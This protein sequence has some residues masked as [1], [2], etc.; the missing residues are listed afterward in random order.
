MLATGRSVREARLLNP[1]HLQTLVT[2]VR[3]GSFADAAR[4]LGYTPSAVS[5][6]IAALERAVRVP[7]FE[8]QAHSITPS[9]TAHL[10]ATRAQHALSELG[11]LEADV[12]AMTT[13]DIGFV[14]VGSF[15]TASKRIVPRWLAAHHTTTPGIDVAFDEDEP[16]ELL[17]KILD[18]RLD[19]ALMYRYDHVPRQWP[20]G[21]QRIPVFDE[22]LLVLLPDGHTLADEDRSLDLAD[23]ADEHW[24]TTRPN[25]DGARCVAH[26]CTLSG[27]TQKVLYRSNDYSV[28]R[29]FVALELGVAVVPALGW[30]STPGVVARRAEGLDAQRHIFALKRANL[31]HRALDVVLDGMRATAPNLAPVLDDRR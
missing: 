10:I 4:E 26:L 27:F 3:T 13:G 7:L 6:Q 14:R 9:P 22:D 20:S 12:D 2:V 15:P 25:T 19:M 28:V 1:T 31:S 21:L 18:G 24:I 23:L 8:R 11:A 17:R 5:Q 30:E 29:E 16:P